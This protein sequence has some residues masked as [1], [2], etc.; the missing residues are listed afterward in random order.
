MTETARESVALSVVSVAQINQEFPKCLTRPTAQAALACP[1]AFSHPLFL[2]HSLS[3]VRDSLNLVAEYCSPVCSIVGTY[4]D[5]SL[6]V[7]VWSPPRGFNGNNG[8]LFNGN[9][10][11]VC[12]SVDSWKCVQW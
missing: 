10:E 3:L 6:G 9:R 2:F 4:A 5:S 1:H 7:D 11:L 12:F 8:N